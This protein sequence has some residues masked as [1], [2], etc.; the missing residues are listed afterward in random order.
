M[1]NENVGAINQTNEVEKGETRKK[2]VVSINEADS[3]KN[4]KII[5]GL[6]GILSFW[7]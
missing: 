7:F 6:V 2:Q 1:V 4:S 5:S 3:A